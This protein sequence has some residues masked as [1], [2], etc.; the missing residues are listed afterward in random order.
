ML[1]YPGKVQERVLCQRVTW[2]Q[3]A[4]DFSAALRKT[5]F[6]SDSSGIR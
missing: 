4:G 1:G 5:G 6:T 2:A 3:D